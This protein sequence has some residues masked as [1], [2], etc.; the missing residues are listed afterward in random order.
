MSQVVRSYIKYWE[1][2]SLS[3]LVLVIQITELEH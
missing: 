1:K 2:R 3:K